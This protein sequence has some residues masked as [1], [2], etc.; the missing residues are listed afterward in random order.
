[1]LGKL[2]THVTHANA[3]TT[4]A[5]ANTTGFRDLGIKKTLDSV[6]LAASTVPP[7]GGGFATAR[8]VT[9]QL[10]LSAG[11]SVEARV[12]QTSGGA[13]KVLSVHGGQASPGFEMSWVAP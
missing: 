13:L 5:E 3:M 10:R 2:R 8:S 7:T 11:Q 12:Q 6:T 1:M 4:I 9:T